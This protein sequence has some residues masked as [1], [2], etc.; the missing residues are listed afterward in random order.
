MQPEDVSRFLL[1][2]N[3]KT[4]T[5]TLIIPDTLYTSDLSAAT[6]AHCLLLSP[7]LHACPR[8]FPRP[9]KREPR[10]AQGQRRD[11]A[12][13]SPSFSLFIFYCLKDETFTGLLVLVCKEGKRN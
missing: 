12:R 2:S 4:V 7:A 9:R 8:L 13:L 11:D 3:T 5:L 10:G 1:R 6:T